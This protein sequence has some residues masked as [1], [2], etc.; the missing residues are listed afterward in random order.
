[1]SM[2]MMWVRCHGLPCHHISTQM[3][4]PPSSTHKMRDYLVEKCCLSLQ[5]S[6]T[7][8]E[9]LWLG[10]LQLLMLVFHPSAI[11]LLRGCKYRLFSLLINLQIVFSIHQG[12]VW[13]QEIVKNAITISLSPR[14][15]LQIACFVH[16]PN[17]IYNNIRQKNSKS[18]QCRSWSQEMIDIATWK[19]CL[20]PR[21]GEKG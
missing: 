20:E 6:S 21:G 5:Q 16:Q 12:I 18:L 7:R 15:H 1:M 19:K 8:W 10:A 17:P 4:L 13:L 3:T 14:S 11:D 9:N 2:K